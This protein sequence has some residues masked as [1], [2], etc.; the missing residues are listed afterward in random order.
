ML[1]PLSPSL[2][3]ESLPESFKA[4]DSDTD[5]CSGGPLLP[6]SFSLILGEPRLMGV[7]WSSAQ[8][9]LW[10]SRESPFSG[11]YPLPSEGELMGKEPWAPAEKVP[12]M[13]TYTFSFQSNIKAT[14]KCWGGCHH[15]CLPPPALQM[16]EFS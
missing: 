5:P 15:H 6:S 14:E 10:G 16:T 13:P 12:L 4:G 2:S 9:E 11:A 8:E 3:S 7:H 1:V